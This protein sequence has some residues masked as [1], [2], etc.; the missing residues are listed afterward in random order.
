M[1]DITPDDGPARVLRDAGY[2]VVRCAP[3]GH[4]GFPCDG[5]T[6]RCPLD[7]TV[8]VAVV[9]HDRPSN[10]I[11]PSE[12][13]VV[14]ALRDGVPLVVAGN[15]AHSPFAG[16]AAA[17]AASIDDI[18]AACARATSTAAARASVVVSRF[19][20]TDATVERHGAAVRVTIGPDAAERHAV[21]AHQ[22]A[23]RLFPRARTVEVGRS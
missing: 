23:R 6:G 10:D 4:H 1:H 21:L 17:E 13:G 19:A 16:A 11:A 2:D 3:A 22:A 15:H 14:C 9:V 7:A 12:A 5:A 8:D 18:P 20:G